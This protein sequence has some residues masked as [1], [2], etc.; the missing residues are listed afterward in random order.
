MIER[1]HT[2]HS[3]DNIEEYLKCSIMTV[4]R[5][6]MA[7]CTCSNINSLARVAR[8][9][10]EIGPEGV[11][12]RIQDPR[13]GE[14][15]GKIAAPNETLAFAPPDYFLFGWWSGFFVFLKYRWEV[16]EC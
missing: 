5:C 8:T 3:I 13:Q 6:V 7:R 4:M 12:S 15:G 14:A 1:G 9:R 10:Q 11:A 16:C 2:T